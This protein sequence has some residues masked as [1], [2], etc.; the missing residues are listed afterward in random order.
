MT[1]RADPHL[2]PKMAGDGCDSPPAVSDAELHAGVDCQDEIQE[3]QARHRHAQ[4]QRHGRQ[5]VE[6]AAAQ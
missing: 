6:E 1:L 2:Q 5:E 3:K 4:Q